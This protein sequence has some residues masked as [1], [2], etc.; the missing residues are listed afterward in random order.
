M[1]LAK[2]NALERKREMYFLTLVENQ[3]KQTSAYEFKMHCG[4]VGDRIACS[5]TLCTR[6]RQETQN[7]LQSLKS[8]SV[9]RVMYALPSPLCERRTYARRFRSESKQA[10]NDRS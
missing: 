5:T 7:L 1:K 8:S 2:A 3:S 10:L 4:R 6:E 9:A